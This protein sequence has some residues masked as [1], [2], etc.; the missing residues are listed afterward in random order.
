MED[1][2]TGGL[3]EMTARRRA[4]GV[5]VAAAREAWSRLD[6][7][8][9]TVAL[10][11]ARLQHRLEQGRVALGV[12]GLV[13]RGKS[14][15]VNALLGTVA[16]PMGV[17]PE[18]AVPV[19]AREGPEP[20][21]RVRLVDGTTH[22]VAPQ[23]VRLWTSQEH[24]AGNHRGVVGVEWQL[25]SAFLRH[26]VVVLDTPGLDDVDRTFTD[27]TL[28]QLEEVDVGL[29]VVAAPPTIGATEMGHLRH[30]HDRHGARLLVACNVNEHHAD[31]PETVEDV[32]AYVR[33]HVAEAGE[34][35][36]VVP[37]CATRALRACLDGDAAGWE[38]AGGAMLLARLEE[39]ASRIAG[40]RLVTAATDELD[41]VLARALG[42]LDDDPA[43]ED[44]DVDTGHETA[45]R[46]ALAQVEDARLQAHLQLHGLFDRA[47]QRLGAHDPAALADRVAA[48][49]LEVDAC[50]HEIQRRIAE[51][52]EHL[53]RRLDLPVAP[54]DARVHL[55]T[56][57]VAVDV[58]PRNRVGG[59]AGGMVGLGIAGLALGPLGVVGGA[60]VGWRLGGLATTEAAVTSAR[61][62]V[63]D[64]LGAVHD[65]LVARLDR[66]LD[67]E[68]ALVRE[69]AQDRARARE[70]DRHR[71]H[72]EAALVA[73]V[74]RRLTD[75]VADAPQAATA[76]A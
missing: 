67:H 39:L 33:A 23:D 69:A 26:G 46:G 21:A 35:V 51:R 54:T 3:G 49:G 56:L 12:F 11:L 28:Q 47:R 36:T 44:D 63:L 66:H 52:V 62:Q 72:D 71:R 40:P 18:T 1:P 42:Q 53:T 14:T 19:L 25:P 9:G 41:T 2:G 38:A 74:R 61:R 7:D 76:T 10:D 57:E 31:D 8:D 37:V 30:L 60:L 24:N 16:S 27:R 43:E 32:V 15:L 20:A 45:L 64:Q 68:I 55:G 22:V 13:K 5:R 17:T 58:D 75:V 4:L 50:L 6:A 34:D 73:D 59:V 48:F 29:V 70:A 65:D